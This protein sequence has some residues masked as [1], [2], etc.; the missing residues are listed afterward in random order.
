MKLLIYCLNYA[1]ELTG[2]GKYAAEQAEW[3]A[4]HGHDV[5]VITSHPYYPAWRVADDHCG[6]R[7][8][9]EQRAGVTVFRAPLW[10][11]HT[12]SSIKRLLHLASFALCSLPLLAAQWRWRPEV[13]FLVEPPLACSPAALAFARLRHCKAWLHI[14]D[15]EVEAAFALGLLKHPWLELAASALERHALMHFDRISTISSSMLSLA[16]RKAVP[17]ERLVYLP[18]WAD[19]AIAPSASSV[20]LRSALGIP[21]HAVAALYSG[22]M[23]NKQ[24][25]EILAEAAR[26]LAG[27]TGIHFIFC[28]AGPGRALLEQRCQ[29]LPQ[30]HFLAL[31]P[32]EQFPAL[33][34]AAD[35]HLLPQR[36]DAADLVL[37]SKLAGM[38][39]SGRPVIATAEA[40]TELASL[41][42]QFGIVTPPGDAQ[43][44]VR[45]L[46]ALAERPARRGLFGAAGKAWAASHLDRHAVLA[47]LESE[48]RRLTED[49]G[50]GTRGTTLEGLGEK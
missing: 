46:Q 12:P 39:A 26:L 31:Q 24:G 3:L 35:I 32:A 30:V 27:E 42:S 33:L 2:I 10:V 47:R 9:R 4:M 8:Q 22:N 13:I 17:D 18:N 40:G 45:A 23:G 14:Q 37:P 28:G 6:W 48:L 19:L 34:G 38:L 11:P 21:A 43:A 5:R 20:A 16:R 49:G 41:V 15:Y 7:Y 29:D 44:M 1:P 50:A 25:L 36:A